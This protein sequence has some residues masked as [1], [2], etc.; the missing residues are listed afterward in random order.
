[1]ATVIDW[2]SVKG[3][4]VVDGPTGKTLSSSPEIWCNGYKQWPVDIPVTAPVKTGQ[5]GTVSVG[6]AVFNIDAN[7]DG[8][9]SVTGTSASDTST[10]YATFTL[11]DG[12]CW[13]DGYASKSRSVPYSLAKTSV[14]F[15]LRSGSSTTYYT[16]SG[17]SP[18]GTYTWGDA[19][20]SDALLGFYYSNY[21]KTSSG[22]SVAN[23][24]GELVGWWDAIASGTYTA[25]KST[26]TLYMS[27]TVSDGLVSV[28]ATCYPA[29]L[30]LSYEW[31]WSS[32]AA[33]SGAS[34]TSWNVDLYSMPDTDPTYGYLY[35]TVSSAE[36]DTYEAAS[37]T[38]GIRYSCASSDH[39]KASASAV[40]SRLVT[41]DGT[42]YCAW[43]I[44]AYTSGSPYTRYAVRRSSSSDE[45]AWGASTYWRQYFV[46]YSGRGTA[47]WTTMKHKAYSGGSF[48]YGGY[49]T[50]AWY[51]AY[52]RSSLGGVTLWVGYS[53]SYYYNYADYV[54]GAADPA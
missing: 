41:I 7:T 15:S 28:S 46:P 19:I 27:Y 3:I 21:V 29:S 20:D 12:Y 17:F 54:S 11:A 34:G 31:K 40:K 52:N 9:A 45:S 32:G 24:S 43:A 49:T 42:S 38:V 25:A 37:Y 13:A 1:M 23:P 8:V 33:V 2:N 35:V 53:S 30:S 5:T 22:L 39:V 4:E 47:A 14:S 44:P 10:H 50:G 18:D 36:T 48:S 51:N 6:V 16:V 26:P